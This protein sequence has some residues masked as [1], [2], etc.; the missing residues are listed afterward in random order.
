MKLVFIR[1]GDP[2]YEV[3]GLT[4]KGEKEAALLAEFIERYKIDEIYMSPL[5]RAQRTAEYSL[6]ALGK[7]AVTLDWLMEFPAKF[8]P[9][10][11]ESARQAYRTELKTDP[12]TGKYLTRI[13]WDILPSYYAGHPELFDKDAW[14][15][16]EPVMYSDMCKVYD[17]VVSSFDEFLCKY[18]YEKDGLIFNVKES[19]DKVIA[20]FCH[21]GI[22]SVLLSHLWN[23]SPFVPLQFMALAP[24]SVT[25]VASEERE[26]GIGTFRT[27]GMGDISHLNIAG[28]E[29]SFSARFCEIYENENERH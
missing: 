17:Y 5:G 20:F 12:A 13:L 14:R 7:E 4:E 2:D 23:V 26:K 6:K 27:I 22:T 21:Y 9:N 11:S 16:A 8:D 1:H 10:L 19:N 28:E 18:G 29:P 3:D 15:T 25:V 24:T